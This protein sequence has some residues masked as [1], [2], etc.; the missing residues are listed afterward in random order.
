MNGWLDLA[1]YTRALAARG[2]D[3]DPFFRPE[4]LRAAAVIG[5]GHPAA[6]A[7][8]G[9][10]YPFL[11]R[12]L[13]GGR[14][15]L[16]A[17]YGMGGPLGRGPWREA[18]RAECARR[19]VVSEFVRF[20]PLLGNQE[21]LDDVRRWKLQDAVTVDVRADDDGLLAQMEGRGRT[22]VRR[23]ARA[24]VQVRAHRDLERFGELYRDTMERIGAEPFYHF[25]AAFFAALEPLGD[26][27]V[28]LDTG[29]A[30]GLFL[31]GNG[32]MHYFLA[33]STPEA[34]EVAAANL[35]LFAAMQRARDHGLRVLS[36]GGGLRDGDALHRFKAAMGAGRAPMWLGAAVHDEPAYRALCAEAG[37]APDDPF[38]PAYRRPASAT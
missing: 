7:A 9:A 21:G 30:A 10:L 36:L 28:V 34:R 4:Y 37:V 32:A 13:D 8:E 33:A 38:F 31:T 15:D 2:P 3:P 23:A 35:V 6:F 29:S 16:T 27:A 24:G 18:F 1:G 22:A 14:C 19:G 25:P 20:H 17:A 12:P 11:V 26:A 5:E